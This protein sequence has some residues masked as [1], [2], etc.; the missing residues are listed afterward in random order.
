MSCSIKDCTGKGHF[1]NGVEYFV[2]GLCHN[3]YYMKWKH[4]KGKKCSL[5]GCER[6]V[7]GRGYCHNHYE[8][9]RK[10][11]PL[12]ESHF[13]LRIQHG[14]AEKGKE[15]YLYSTWSSM[16]TRCYNPNSKFY[17]DYGGRGIAVCERWDNFA[18]FIE[19]MG[20]RPEG[21]TLERKNNDL[22]YSPENCVW[23]TRKEQ[24]N[25]RRVRVYS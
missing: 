25:N 2:K 11:L 15:H 6:R 12:G 7:E 19:D 13:R 20:E 10:G 23:A 14:L 18:L 9:F 8:R 5:E 4:E 16:R 3:H 24:A 17:A 1:F 22:G 21:M